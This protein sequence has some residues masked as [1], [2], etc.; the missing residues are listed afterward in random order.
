[1]KLNPESL[2]NRSLLAAGCAEYYDAGVT[3]D[4]S[5]L[6]NQL[7][8]TLDTP[9]ALAVGDA[10]ATAITAQSLSLNHI[11][12]PGAACDAAV[13]KPVGC[14]E[15]G[16]FSLDG[17]VTVEL[18]RG[19]DT[20][21]CTFEFSK[22]ALVPQ[23]SYHEG[24]TGLPILKNTLHFGD[25]FHNSTLASATIAPFGDVDPT[26]PVVAAGTVAKL[27]WAPTFQAQ[28][29]VCADGTGSIVQVVTNPA[30]I[31]P[32]TVT[33]ATTD[34]DIV[35]KTAG[36]VVVALGGSAPGKLNLAAV[37]LAGLQL[38]AGAG[39][40]NAID[41]NGNINANQLNT[42]TAKALS[43]AAFACYDNPGTC[44]SIG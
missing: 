24:V 35:A 1:M 36:D 11:L 5:A 9:L 13:I 22:I 42:A 44:K 40:G 27:V 17:S 23:S 15:A 19:A 37:G 43:D 25:P 18:T 39:V 30:L 3:L 14:Y 6:A 20:R 41:Y 4:F 12:I 31:L 10:V 7:T 8:C 34:F 28:F 26:D 33:P 38:G 16:K 21:T 2:E 29:D 32:G